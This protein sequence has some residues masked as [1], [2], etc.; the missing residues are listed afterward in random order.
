MN[1]EEFES[2]K[3]EEQ[4]KVVRKSPSFFEKG[5]LILHAHY[6]DKLTQSFSEEELYLIIR[7]LDPEERYELIKYANLPQLIFISDIDCWEKDRLYA[8]GF[9][10][11]LDTLQNA[12]ER[13]LLGWLVE[14]DYETV[15]SGFKKI[16]EVIKPEW[17]Y[18]SDEVLGD[19]PYFTLDELYFIS[20][21][22]ENLQTVRRAMELLFEN[23]RGRYVAIL[24]GMLGELDDL[25]EE[26]AFD[27]REK[28]L[29]DKGFPDQET[30]YQVFKPMTR[31]EFEA[32]PKK[33]KP[34]AP[35]TSKT[36]A[37][38]TPNY[39]MLWSSSQMFLDEI[40]VRL[41]QESPEE[42]ES[43]KEQLAW[44]ANKIIAAR[45]L[46]FS[47]ERLVR[48]GVDRAK[49]VLNLGFEI[50]CGRDVEKAC[51]YAREHWIETIFRLACGSL[52]KLREEAFHLADQYWEGEKKAFI[53]F[54]DTPYHE[55]LEG[56]CQPILPVSYNPAGEKDESHFHDFSNVQSVERTRSSLQQLNKIF[57]LMQ[58]KY[59][60]NIFKP[61]IQK[62]FTRTLFGFLGTFFAQYVLG[63][64]GKKDFEELA[65]S[66]VKSLSK[67][68]F[69]N[70]HPSKIDT[71]V[72][73]GFLVQ[74]FSEEDRNLL[75]SL[76]GLVFQEIEEELGHL[77][78]TKKI[79]PE[80]IASL[81]IKD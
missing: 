77:D 68:L 34:A 28:R 31:E 30:A 51:Q 78:L 22:E 39:L 75:R 29:I 74:C 17:E 20:V 32:Y 46:D 42:A 61:S 66:E 37:E 76:W 15:V 62:D 81:W 14:S 71:E 58:K 27:K 21:E 60:K 11:W 64:D 45:G 67:K 16:M 5:D 53:Q 8:K 56:L 63:Q 72:K 79:Q 6:P 44:L 36:R 70:G 48:E 24:E 54:L 9:L 4:E 55:I 43:F 40:A 3:P 35:A 50:L 19:R 33:V 41:A 59:G 10:R 65:A 73:E 49:S 47:S 69:K 23:H 18:P 38:K 13:R 7:E 2:L 25:V 12:D 80:Y 52:L 1:H 26:Q 57:I